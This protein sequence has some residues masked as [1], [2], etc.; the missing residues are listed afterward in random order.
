MELQQNPKGLQDSTPPDRDSGME[1]DE[2]A[3]I[4]RDS[5][6]RSDGSLSSEY[7]DKHEMWYT[8]S[9]SNQSITVYSPTLQWYTTKNCY[10]KYISLIQQADVYFNLNILTYNFRT[11]KIAA[12]IKIASAGCNNQLL[13]WLI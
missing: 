8:K 1:S 12:T 13:N 9:G 6:H 5:D 2:S 7:D 10:L 4:N 11:V 3:K